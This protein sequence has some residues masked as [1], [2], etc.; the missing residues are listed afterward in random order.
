MLLLYTHIE[1]VANG[2]ICNNAICC[3]CIMFFCN[4]AP[5]HSKS[6][7]AVHFQGADMLFK[8]TH[9][10]LY[11]SSAEMLVCT[12]SALTYS[13]C[14]LFSCRSSHFAI[15][16]V[17][18]SLASVSSGVAILLRVPEVLAWS[19]HFF[20]GRCVVW[21]SYT[22]IALDEDENGEEEVTHAPNQNGAWRLMRTT[23]GA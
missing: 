14:L 4:I 9:W 19:V 13:A 6:W 22:P 16:L 7:L 11:F 10:M 18:I 1:R 8:A 5:A 20:G 3:T 15:R 23:S 21:V 12:L 2:I 17:G